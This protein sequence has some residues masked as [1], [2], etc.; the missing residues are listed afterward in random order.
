MLGGIVTQLDECCL[1]QNSDLSRERDASSQHT[2][3]PDSRD[4]LHGLG[5]VPTCPAEQQPTYQPAGPG[6]TRASEKPESPAHWSGSAGLA[7]TAV[8]MQCPT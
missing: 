6:V 1:D 8:C 4:L 3:S 7:L 5:R 2:M